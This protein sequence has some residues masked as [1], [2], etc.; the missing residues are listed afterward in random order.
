MEKDQKKSSLRQKLHDKYKLTILN[1]AFEE[2]FSIELSKLNVFLVLSL[3]ALVLI[4]LTTL[5]IA[6]TPLKEYIPGF[7]SNK[8]NRKLYLLQIQL[9]S[10]SSRLNAYDLYTQNLQ[11]VIV[12]EDFSND[13]NA[14]HKKTNSPDK[15]NT[16]AFSKQD[17]L[18]LN[19]VM[20]QQE[21][22]STTSKRIKQKNKSERKM[23]FPPV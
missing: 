17:S 1:K 15:A 16:F 21:D 6:L 2:K 12:N 20:Q 9:D 7:G 5:L 8:E 14:F 13:T 4:T 19:I 22:N 3:S 10:L 11:Q 23:L 18:L